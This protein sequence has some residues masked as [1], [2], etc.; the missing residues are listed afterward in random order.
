ML[1]TIKELK[2]SLEHKRKVNETTE[3]WFYT[4]YTLYGIYC[5]NS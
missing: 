1:P 4:V 3:N 2:K 5:Y